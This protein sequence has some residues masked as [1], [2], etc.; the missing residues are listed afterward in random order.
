MC[1]LVLGLGVNVIV[2]VIP[3]C[4]GYHDCDSSET[5]CDC[6]D[7]S[8]YPQICGH[9][10]DLWIRICHLL[11]LNDIDCLNDTNCVHCWGYHP[12]CCMYPPA[13]LSAYH[14]N[15]QGTGLSSHDETGPRSVC[16]ASDLLSLCE[17][18]GLKIAYEG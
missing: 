17:M 15:D 8:L 3:D 4:A 12:G 7:Q 16:Q 1:L 2:I 14:H 5:L 9:Q 11:E 6:G 18:G 13:G 10:I